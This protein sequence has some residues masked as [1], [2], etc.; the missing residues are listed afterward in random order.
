M[1]TMERAGFVDQVGRENFL[2]NIDAAIALAA[3]LVDEK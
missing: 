1:R 2:P 3:V